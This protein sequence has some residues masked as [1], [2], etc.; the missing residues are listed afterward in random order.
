MITTVQMAAAKT[1][2]AKKNHQERM[3]CKSLRKSLGL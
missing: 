2:Q 1:R 3:F